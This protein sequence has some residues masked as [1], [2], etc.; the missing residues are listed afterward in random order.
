MF[1]RVASYAS[2]IQIYFMCPLNREVGPPIILLS[3]VFFFFFS[4]CTRVL[5]KQV[6]F[7]FWSLCFYLQS[8]VENESEETMFWDAHYSDIKACLTQGREKTGIITLF[9]LAGWLGCL[10]RCR[11]MNTAEEMSG[12]DIHENIVCISFYFAHLPWKKTKG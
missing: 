9:I 8:S 6:V 7:F 12:M 11:G 5:L 1:W 2:I 3:R 10:C 4:S